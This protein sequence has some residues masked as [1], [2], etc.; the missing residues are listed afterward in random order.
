[1]AVISGSGGIALKG[2]AQNFEGFISGSGHIDAFGLVSTEAQ[3]TI[4]GSGNCEVNVADFLQVTS[5]GSGNV[6]Y[7]GS[8]RINS[9]INGSGDVVAKDWR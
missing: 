1:M 5:T 8:P 4:S 9:R 3:V 2:K 7:S 6:Y